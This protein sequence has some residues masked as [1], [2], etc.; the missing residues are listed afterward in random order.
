MICQTCRIPIPDESR[1]CYK[2]GASQYIASE[3]DP[4]QAQRWETCIIDCFLHKEPFF[5]RAT[6][7][8]EAFAMGPRGPYSAGRSPTFKAD[9]TLGTMSRKP[10]DRV[11]IVQTKRNW[12]DLQQ[13]VSCLRELGGEALPAQPENWYELHFRRT[14]A[15]D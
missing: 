1:F 5:G 2:C 12:H 15:V 9:L 11:R 13:F 10:G 6:V 3:C 7:Y 4:A 14:T 8:F